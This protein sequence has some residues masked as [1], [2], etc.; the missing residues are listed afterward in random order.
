M[1]ICRIFFSFSFLVTKLM[2]T[3]ALKKEPAKS[4]GMMNDF[5][6]FLLHDSKEKSQ[7]FRNC[8]VYLINL[9]LKLIAKKSRDF[10]FRLIY[11]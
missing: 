6:A 11:H 10:E 8:N 7:Q 2:E 5:F 4:Y 3:I 1:P 9:L